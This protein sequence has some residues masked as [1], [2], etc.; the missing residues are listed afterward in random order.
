[1][2]KDFLLKDFQNF[3][4][5]KSK[6]KSTFGGHDTTSV[7][8]YVFSNGATKTEHVYDDGYNEVCEDVVE[9]PV[10]QT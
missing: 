5:T 8:D 7:C 1:M 2:K 9:P 3:E 6:C 4:F 10:T